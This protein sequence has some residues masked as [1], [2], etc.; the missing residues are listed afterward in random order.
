[1]QQFDGAEATGAP[2]VLASPARETPAVSVIMTAYNS[3][4]YIEAALR[5]IMDQTL[6]EIEIIVVDDAS[7]DGTAEVLA[8]LA[9]EEP[10]LCVLTHEQNLGPALGRNRALEAARAPYVAVLDSDDLAP[11]ERLARQKAWLDSHPATVLLA[12]SVRLIDAEGR[13]IRT[14]RRARDAI[15]TRWMARFNMP[16]VHPTAMFR[17]HMPGKKPLAYDPDLQV[18]QDYDLVAQALDLGEAVALAEVL[19][20]YRVHGTSL[21]GTRWR[22][23]QKVASAIALR[24]QK[25]DLPISI[26]E[27]LEPFR[28][29]YF[30]MRPV[31]PHALFDGLRQMLAHDAK[32]APG[33]RV[34][35]K[36]QAAQLAA[37]A[38]HRSRVGKRRILQAF[39]GSGRDFLLP[40][41][42]RYLETKRLLPK[43][44]SSDLNVG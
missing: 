19:V 39:L 37:T 6:R 24:R 16:I 9:T 27:A 21:T 18:A 41:T 17:R 38:F 13:H 23:Q 32:T 2:Q 7:S 25:A 44:L 15:A 20:H 10:R 12:G 8:R 22:D 29:A 30:G 33:H 35:M 31:D 14:R 3:A 26:V 11:P 5:S 43:P 28:E 42:F 1:M 36:R 34:W 4:A 40:L